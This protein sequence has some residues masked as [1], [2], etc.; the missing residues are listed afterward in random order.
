MKL[1]ELRNSE[2]LVL[3]NND[4][5]SELVTRKCYSHQ[6]FRVK[7]NQRKISCDVKIWLNAIVWR[8][9]WLW[10]HDRHNSGIPDPK[11]L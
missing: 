3:V 9:N 2:I 4:K 10:R 5:I 6:E 8:H 7:K 11:S 1:K